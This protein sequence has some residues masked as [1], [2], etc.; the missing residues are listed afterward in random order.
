MARDGGYTPSTAPAAWAFFAGRGR[1]PKFHHPVETGRSGGLRTQRSAGGRSRDERGA[2]HYP[3]PAGRLD[4]HRGDPPARPE[5]D[6]G[7]KCLAWTALVDRCS[8]A[9]GREPQ[10]GRGP[11]TVQLDNHTACG[12]AAMIKDTLHHA[13][14]FTSPDPCAR[15]TGI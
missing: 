2:G 4:R 3:G 7:Q 9:A 5:L 6:A 1:V 8:L 10:I 15:D 13:M 12:S 14:I 11:Y